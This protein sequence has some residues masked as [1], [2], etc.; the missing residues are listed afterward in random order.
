M[1][2]LLVDCRA[3]PNSAQGLRGSV[4]RNFVGWIST[5]DVKGG[6]FSSGELM[7]ILFFFEVADHRSESV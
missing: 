6:N 2:G 4:E 5:D 1:V 3:L 7:F